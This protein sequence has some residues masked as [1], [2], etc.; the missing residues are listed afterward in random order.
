MEYLADQRGFTAPPRRQFDEGSHTKGTLFV[1]EPEEVASRMITF[2]RQTGH[3]RHLLPTDV[4]QL[5]HRDLLRSIELFGT[6]VKPLVDAEL[7]THDAKVS[8]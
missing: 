6:G 7:G 2:Q 5:P 3:T 8:A 1:G 4:G